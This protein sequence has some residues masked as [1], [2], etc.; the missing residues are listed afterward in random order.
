M[1]QPI[2][3]TKRQRK[4]QS[5]SPNRSIHKKRVKKHIKQQSHCRSK[6]R[7]PAKHQRQPKPSD[8][9][10]LFQQIMTGLGIVLTH[11]TI[12]WFG[13]LIVGILLAIAKR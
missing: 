1:R 3:N 10:L 9:F 6:Q 13:V 7:R 4:S 2:N 5:K 11:R 8:P 12:S